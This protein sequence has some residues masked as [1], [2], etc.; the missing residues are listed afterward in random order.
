M[1]LGMVDD[2]SWNTDELGLGGAGDGDG[3]GNGAYEDGNNSNPRPRDRPRNNGCASSAAVADE[4]SS[5]CAGGA[6][7]RDGD[8]EAVGCD[9]GREAEG[10][11]GLEGGTMVSRGGAAG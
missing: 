5:A 2:G 7:D 4:S 9:A 1:R 8:T 3:G 11:T 10:N 6:C